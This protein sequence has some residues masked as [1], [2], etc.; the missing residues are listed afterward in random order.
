MFW[1]TKRYFDLECGIHKMLNEYRKNN[2]F[3]QCSYED[4]EDGIKMYLSQKSIDYIYDDAVLIPALLHNLKWLETDNT[5]S[6]DEDNGVVSIISECELLDKVKFWM[7]S[8]DHGLFKYAHSSFWDSFVSLLKRNF[9][10]SPH[11]EDLASQQRSWSTPLAYSMSRLS[12][13]DNLYKSIRNL[14]I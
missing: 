3:F 7:S 10:S 13:D 1:M 4:I 8:V 14:F 6:I 12:I 5:F 11:N 9:T 2:E